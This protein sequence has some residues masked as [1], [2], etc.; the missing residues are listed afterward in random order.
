MPLIILSDHPGALVVFDGAGDMSATGSVS[1]GFE[2][3]FNGV[4]DMIANGS[5]LR[6]G[7]VSFD[8]VGDMIAQGR[9]DDE[10]N[11]FGSVAFDGVGDLEATGNV[12][13][14]GLVVFDG[15]GDLIADARVQAAETSTLNILLNIVESG[16]IAHGGT[17]SARILADAVGYPIRSYQFT[18]AGSDA[19]ASLDVTLQRNSDRPAILAA[20]QF[21]FDLH[22]N[23]TWVSMFEGGKRIGAGYSFAFSDGRPSDSLSVSS[24]APTAEKLERSPENNLTVYDPSRIT[25]SSGDFHSV[26]DTD[27]NEYRQ[28]LRAVGGLSLYD[29]LQIVFVEKCGFAGFQTTLDDFPIRRCDFSITGSWFSGI[30]GHVGYYNPYLFVIND[31]VWFLDSTTGFPAGFGDPSAITADRYKSAQFTIQEL[32]ADG[33]IVTFAENETDYDYTV[34]RTVTDPPAPI[35]NFGDPDFQETTRSRQYREYYKTSQPL[36]PVKSEKLIETTSRRA[37]VDGSSDLVSK[38]TETFVYDSL[39]RYSQIL[40]VSEGL[41]PNMATEDFSLTFDLVKRKRTRFQYKA[42]RF[43]P[44]RQILASRIEQTEGLIAIDTE[45]QLLNND[46][47]QDFTDAFRAGNLAAGIATEF[48]PI[49]TVEEFR[50][51]TSK[52]QIEIKTATTNFLTKP[53]AVTASTTEAQIGDPSGNAQTAGTGEVI[54]LRPGAVRSNAKMQTLAVGELPVRFAVP[55]ARRRLARRSTLRGTVS[56]LGVDLSI[57]RGSMFELFDRDGG[58]LGVFVCEGRTISGSNLGTASQVTQMNLEVVQV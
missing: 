6:E 13:K 53:P 41:I 14:R 57:G 21:T 16:V 36:I 30:A 26:F 45:N 27:G 22:V 46:F 12:A 7:S 32:N 17:Y 1:S 40:K 11:V 56:L 3:R 42:D 31:V 29:L 39:G 48:A 4:G 43:D 10:P 5:V 9:I 50:S 8:G 20:G 54:V 23:G 18:E 44:R 25:L 35:G 49:E 15:V 28:Q 55:L 47:R 19:G 37:M 52:S 38:E 2:V 58:S 51:Q 24:A 33:F 34:L